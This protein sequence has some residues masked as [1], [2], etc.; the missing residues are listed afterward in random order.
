MANTTRKYV[1]LSK[2]SNF[3]DN[4]KNTFA[5]LSH[6]HNLSDISDF[7][8]DA[9]LSPDSS[10]PVQNKVIDAE[11]EAISVAMNALDQAIDTKVDTST[12]SNYSTTSES[13]LYTDNAVSQKTQVQIITWEDDD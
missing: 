11:F 3:L 2:L 5:A 9:A 4:L 6:S 13:Q 8:V 12:L 10:N 1:S 7:T